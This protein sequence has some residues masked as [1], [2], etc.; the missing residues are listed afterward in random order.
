[1]GSTARRSDVHHYCM[2]SQ[3]E[4]IGLKGAFNLD[5]LL[6]TGRV[7]LNLDTEEAG[8]IY[9]GCA[10]EF[11]HELDLQIGKLVMIAC[12][13]LPYEGIRYHRSTLRSR[14]KLI[15]VPN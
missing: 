4:E 13:I 6:L 3:E 5:G 14:S 10:G 2:R 1:M 7:L 12:S 11:C 15:G 9:I 8:Q